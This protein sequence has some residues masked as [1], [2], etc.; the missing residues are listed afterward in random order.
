MYLMVAERAEVG[1]AR[2]ISS[3]ELERVQKTV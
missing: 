3:L 1:R 2:E